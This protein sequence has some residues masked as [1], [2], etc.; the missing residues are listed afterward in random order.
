MIHGYPP[1]IPKINPPKIRGVHNTHTHK[2]EGFRSS[3]HTHVADDVL[4]LRL[5]VERMLL[6]YV[7]MYFPQ[8]DLHMYVDN[9]E[10]R[11]FFPPVLQG[12]GKP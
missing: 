8:V 5:C 6:P 7:C 2:E 10:G 3:P 12:T 1:P 4:T 11:F 9:F